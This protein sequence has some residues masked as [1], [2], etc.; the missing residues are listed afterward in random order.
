MKKLIVPVFLLLGF[1]LSLAP[2]FSSQ[3]TA[4]PV[5]IIVNPSTG[6]SNISKSNLKKVFLG[7]TGE[8]NGTSVTTVKSKMGATYGK[9]RKKILGFSKKKE[10]T[11]WF[12]Q[13]MRGRVKVVKQV[14][15]DRAVAEKVSSDSSG[16]G[17][18]SLSAYESA[19]SQGLS[20]K[21]LK[22]NGFTYSNGSYP[23]N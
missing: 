15:S 4:E 9:F 7:K 18:V 8:I 16:I 17:I 11:Y 1:I 21:A 3:A 6:Y 23:L 20:V 12:R 19:R 10:K 13:I 22:I 14:D 5:V 2:G